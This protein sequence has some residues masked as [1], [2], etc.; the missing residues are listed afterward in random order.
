MTFREELI[1]SKATLTGAGIE[2]SMEDWRFERCDL[3][4]EKS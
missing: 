2:D 1:E 3:R 4:R